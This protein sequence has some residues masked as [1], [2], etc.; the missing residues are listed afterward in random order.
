ML[1]NDLPAFE[2]TRKSDVIRQNLQAMHAA[3]QK[4]IESESS[5]KIQRALKHK[6]RTY[7]ETVFEKGEKVYY[8]RKSD[9]GWKGPAI[10]LA[11]DNKWILIRHG[12]AFYRCHASHVIKKDAW[13]KNEVQENEVIVSEGDI[14]KIKE[15]EIRK[16]ESMIEDDDDSDENNFNNEPEQDSDDVEEGEEE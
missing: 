16:A 3:R 15:V 12:G 11:V 5:E 4:F 9:K 13:L 7:S 14:V 2:P 6:V 1:N 8:K 10:V